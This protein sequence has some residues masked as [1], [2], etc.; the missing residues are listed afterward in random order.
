MKQNGL[1]R[2]FKGQN[3]G[4]TLI[5]LL[6]VISILGII[7]AI[8]IPNVLDNI[9][10]T[11]HAAALEEE[12]NV[13]VAVTVALK[14]GGGTMV[15]DYTSSGI[16]PADENAPVNDPAKYLDKPTQFEWII[17]ATGLLSP[18]TGNPLSP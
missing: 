5:E 10:R 9:G 6:I 12:H 4:F 14:E 2:L 11:R 16:L 1:I 18:G 8:A 13:L 7:A 3:K 17:T 15:S